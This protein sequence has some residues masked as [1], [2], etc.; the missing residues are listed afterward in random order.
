[1]GES[2]TFCP[3]TFAHAIYHTTFNR[4]SEQTETDISCDKKTAKSYK[5]SIEGQFTLDESEHESN[6]NVKESQLF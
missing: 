3:T 4:P 1:M 6:V 2:N 5:K